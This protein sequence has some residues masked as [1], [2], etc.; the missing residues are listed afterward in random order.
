MQVPLLF[1]FVFFVNIYGIYF[2]LQLRHN[3]S[4]RLLLLIFLITF[5]QFLTGIFIRLCSPMDINLFL[6]FPFSLIFGPIVLILFT[7]YQRGV[8]K[9]VYYL[10]FLPFVASVSIFILLVYNA[11]FR[12]QYYDQFFIITSILSIVIYFFYL[13]WI[14][15]RLDPTLEHVLFGPFKIW[16]KF[17]IPVFVVFIFIV[18][19]TLLNS[20]QGDLLTYQFVKILH[21]ILF[22]CPLLQFSFH[23]KYDLPACSIIS[24]TVDEQDFM[25]TEK[26]E[27]VVKP[28]LTVEVEF[29][30][31]QKIELFI[32]SKGYLDM[33]LNRD[34]FCKQLDIKRN[35]LG[36]F[37]KKY[38]NRNFNGFINQQRLNYA[39]RLLSREDFV[40]TIDDL[41]FICGFRSRA[42]FYRNFISEF[43]C[44]PHEYRTTVQQFQKI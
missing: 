20:E 4:N 32:A 37:L 6:I 38:C 2:N 30:Y 23:S 1:L 21:L 31:R 22:I 10:H 35:N 5:L 42:S 14:G 33:D 26:A 17:M 28:I 25:Q 16:K 15:L 13:S 36:P 9:P 43:G 40:Y 7:Y 39:T 27:Q 34:Q 3:K 11:P 41:S 18:A 19:I 29:L 44:S 8:I 12:Y 24:R